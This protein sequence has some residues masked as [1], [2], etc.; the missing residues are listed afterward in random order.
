MVHR[1]AGRRRRPAAVPVPAYQRHGPLVD[2]QL[3]GVRRAT[4]PQLSGAA[5]LAACVGERRHRFGAAESAVA[6]GA[7]HLHPA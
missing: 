7:E 6:A 2:L 1:G 3:V 4:H 5:S